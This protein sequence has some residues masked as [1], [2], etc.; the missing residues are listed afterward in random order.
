MHADAVAA[1]GTCVAAGFAGVTTIIAGAAAWFARRQ[2][3]EARATRERVA[4]PDVVVFMDHNPKNWQFLDLV[5]K[6]FGQTAAYNIKLT[7][8]PLDVVPFRSGITGETVTELYV[9]KRI[10][11]LAPGQE[12]RTVWFSAVKRAKYEGELRTHFVGNVQF[13]DKMNPDPRDERYKNPISLDTKMFWNLLRLDQTEPAKQIADQI[14]EVAA[15]LKSYHDDDTGVWVYTVPGDE[16]NQRREKEAAEARAAYESLLTDM[17][18]AQ[19][20]H[21]QRTA[22]DAETER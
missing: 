22:N 2:V 21:T 8:P 11:V 9:P 3:L 19:E 16:E 5:I 20:R 14:A 10:A 13:D 6:N 1:L 15:T 18:I 17:G 4:Q 7:L 12:W